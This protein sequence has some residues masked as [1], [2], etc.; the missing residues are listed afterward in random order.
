MNDNTLTPLQ[1]TGPEKIP[2]VM[3]ELGRVEALV[4]EL[5]SKLEYT[6]IASVP[7]GDSTANVPSTLLSY[8]LHTIG[9]VLDH[10]LNNIEL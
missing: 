7:Q 10:I 8:R 3:V 2:V 9:D 1:Q 5:Y 4:S 6:V